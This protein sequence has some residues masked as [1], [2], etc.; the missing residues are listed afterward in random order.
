M[1]NRENRFMLAG[2]AAAVYML[3]PPG[4]QAPP[5]PWGS[6]QRPGFSVMPISDNPETYRQ[7][8]EAKKKVIDRHGFSDMS[9]AYNHFLLQ[10]INLRVDVDFSKQRF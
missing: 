1:G 2:L 4:Q 7:S 6:I 8:V 5:N 3:L 9:A 10:R